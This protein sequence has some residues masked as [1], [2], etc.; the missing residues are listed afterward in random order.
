MA[1][2]S[3]P[4]RYYSIGGLI[5]AKLPAV[6]RCSNRLPM[7]KTKNSGN[8]TTPKPYASRGANVAKG[9][10]LSKESTAYIERAV[11]RETK[12]KKKKE[13]KKTENDVVKRLAK[14][15]LI[16]KD[17]ASGIIKKKS[18]KTKKKKNKGPSLYF[19]SWLPL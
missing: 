3:P 8:S 16:D 7:T 11:G 4:H 17:K 1:E 13:Q 6:L 18:A 9:G 12:R 10:V 5:R 14:N 19:F 15:G 2:S